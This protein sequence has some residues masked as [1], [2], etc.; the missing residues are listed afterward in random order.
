MIRVAA[1]NLSGLPDPGAAATVIQSFEADLVCAVE[2]PGRLSLQRLARRV[3]MEVVGRAGRG[4]LGVAVLASE[5]ARVLSSSQHELARF[6]GLPPR[7]CAQVIASVE[8]SRIAVFAVQLG[9][10]PEAR[11]RHAADLADLLGKVDAAPIVAGDLNEPPGGVANERLAGLVSDAFAVAGEGPGATYPNPDPVA[12]RDY[13]FVAPILEV[14]R[15]WVPD[16]PLVAVAS[17]HRPV[18]ADLRGPDRVER[19]ADSLGDLTAVD[20]EDVA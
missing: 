11:L 1:Y 19:E 9:L 3:G 18:V 7:A 6:Q 8:G 14:A 17:Y 16:D 12:R 15:C 10:R 13:V 5:R 4:R 2:T 20:G